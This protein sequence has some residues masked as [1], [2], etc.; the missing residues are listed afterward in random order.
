MGEI[1]FKVA[2]IL[3]GRPRARAA[4][5]LAWLAELAEALQIPPLSA[6][7]LS[8]ADIPAVVEKA[9][10]ASSMKANPISLT[11]DELVGILEQAV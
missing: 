3:T 8:R 6:Y 5:G 4:K 1:L 7:G 11:H 10:Q 9:A 2:Q